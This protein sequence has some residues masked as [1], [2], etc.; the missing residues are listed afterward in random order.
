MKRLLR[1]MALS[2]LIVS[3][4]S[5]IGFSQYT[6][7]GL[8]TDQSGEPLIGVSVLV[9][10]TT[11]G[12]ITEIDGT[13]TIDVLSDPANLEFNYLGYATSTLE[14]SSDSNLAN[15]SMT[16]SA[17]RLDEVVI[18]GLATTVKRSNLANAVARVNAQDL[19]GIASQSTL[20]GALYG[21]FKGAEIKANSGAPGGG[22]AFKLRGVTSINGSSQ[23]LIILDGVYIDNSSIPGGLN[24]VSAAGAGGSTSNQDNPSNRLADIDPNDIESVEILKGA[25]AAAIYGSRAAGGVVILT[26]K[27]GKSGKTRISFGQSVGKTSQLRKLGV[28]Q[29]TEEKVLGSNF[30][31]DIDN[32]RAGQIHNYED[33]LYGSGGSLFNTRLSVS[34]GDDKTKFF[35]GGSYKNEEG[36]V[37][38]TGY[39]K[40]SVRINLDHKIS[41]LFTATLSSN[42]ISSSADR[43]FF[44]ND[45]SGNTI[46]ISFTSTPSWA[47]LQP[48]DAG[49]Y[50]SNPYAPSNFLETAALITNNESVGRFIGG[51]SITGK[52]LQTDKSSLKAVFRGGIDFYNLSTSAI[53]PNSLQFQRDGAGLNG[54]SVQGFTKNLNSNLAL[55]LVH[56]QYLDNGMSF[57]TS[58]GVTQEDFNQ[59]TI[60]GEATDL[61]GSQT[62]LDQAG[63]R[64]VTQ[65]RRIQQ[66]KGFFA[67]EEVNYKDMI[68]A[69][70]GF[71]GD[72]SSNN[73]D[74]KKLFFYPKANV[75][76]NL[77][78][79]NFWN[80]ASP[81]TQFKVRAAYGES[82]NFARFGS[83]FTTLN[84]TIVDGRAGVFTP[85]LLGNI[86]VGPERQKELEVGIDLE[87]N[88]RF[89]FDA[90]YYIKSVEDLLLEAR[91]PTS[92]GFSSQVTNAASLQNKGIELGLELGLVSSQDF[93]WNARIGFWKN[94][95]EVT[96]LAVPAFTTGGFADFLGNHLIKEGFSPTTL[97]GVGPNPTIA[98][99]EGDTPSLQEFGNAEADFQMSWANNISYNNFDLS[100]IW[101]WKKGGSNINLSTLLFDLN[102]TTHDFD[103]ITLDPEGVL[104]NG[105][106]RLSLLGS[107]TEPYIED[108]GYIRLREIGLYYTLPSSLIPGGGT[109]KIGFSGTNLINIFDY[110]S[111]DPE[112]SNFGANGLSN[113]VEVT[114]FPSSKRFDF[115]IKADF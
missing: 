42:Y 51:G 4:F 58:A 73:G 102:N 26:T 65:N 74:V 56:N 15:L 57:T 88:R 69:T 91:V 28:R 38:K 99:N 55:F 70:V 110:N 94:T 34:G 61:I 5:V 21:K 112:V 52:I 81:I 33:E 1:Q 64:N 67:Q 59:N 92:S 27:R 6:V 83:K 36:I 18:T 45:N 108:S 29:W 72:K 96:D 84:S 3:V 90:T 66:D 41:D 35:I 106:Y 97:I 63:S 7:T 16:E 43:G 12:T 104:G 46:G 50:P 103:D 10:G 11:T 115:H 24:L 78:N 80:S 8:V 87:I 79:F 23:P 111:Y 47:Q 100:F 68:V 19:V 31:D 113:A 98:L 49:V 20:E 53:F 44:N 86:T 107:N 109:F 77:Q 17:S 93:N 71:R 54:A 37:S 95:S 13:Y 30:A 85:S 14:V 2:V 82:G 40:T 101:H 25:S 39:K 114:P 32:F 48:N 89:S 62:N 9:Q 60:L 105:A 22:V 76:I 75:A